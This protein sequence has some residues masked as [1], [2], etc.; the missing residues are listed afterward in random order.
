MHAKHWLGA[1]VGVMALAL[2]AMPATAAPV[3]GTATSVRTA[4]TGS[5]MVEATHWRGRRYGYH[6]GGY[7]GYYPYYYSYPAYSYYA[8]YPYYYSYYSYP[9]YR[10]YYG[11]PYRHYRHYRRW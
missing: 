11:G 9:R 7:G 6:Y 8:P 10:S 3:V 2:W 4:V 5:S 1:T